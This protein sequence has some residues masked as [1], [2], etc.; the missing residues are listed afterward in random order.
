MDIKLWED[1][2]VGEVPLRESFRILYSLAVDPMVSVAELFDTVF[3]SWM[4]RLCRNLND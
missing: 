2:R 4:S 3:N 1:R